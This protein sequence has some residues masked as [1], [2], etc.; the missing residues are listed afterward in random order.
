V[1]STRGAESV[2]V[3]VFDGKTFHRESGPLGTTHGAFYAAQTF[4]DLPERSVVCRSRSVRT[5][6]FTQQF[7]A[8]VTNQSFTLPHE[9][10]LRQTDDGLKQ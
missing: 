3:G 2:F 7:P 10:T 4:S 1:D 6:P 8:Q 5:D 9:L